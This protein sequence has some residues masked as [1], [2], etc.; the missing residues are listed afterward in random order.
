MSRPFEE[1]LQSTGTRQGEQLILYHRGSN[2]MQYFS[3]HKESGSLEY[4][5]YGTA[6]YLFVLPHLHKNETTVLFY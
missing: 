3:T 2:N 4:V 5:L 6:F 1:Y